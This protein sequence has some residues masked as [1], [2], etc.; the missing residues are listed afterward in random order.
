M[1]ADQI[2]KRLLLAFG[3]HFWQGRR[4]FHSN[5]RATTVHLG[6]HTQDT[7]ILR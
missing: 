4:H 1:F 2:V 5:I 7:P 3:V 6:D